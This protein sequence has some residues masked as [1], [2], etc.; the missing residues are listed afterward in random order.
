MRRM[1]G[2]DM[3]MPVIQILVILIVLCVFEPV[4]PF[5][6]AESVDVSFIHQRHN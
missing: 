2:R 4:R 3:C 6:R 1:D 5:C